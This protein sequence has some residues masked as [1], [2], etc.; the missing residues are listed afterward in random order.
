VT[1]RPYDSVAPPRRH[2]E[3]SRGAGD[4]APATTRHS[5]RVSE[6]TCDPPLASSSFDRE[7]GDFIRGKGLP[8][9]RAVMKTA[10]QLER[11]HNRTSLR[12]PRLLRRARLAHGH[13]D[14]CDAADHDRARPQCVQCD[15]G[16][17]SSR[18]LDYIFVSVDDSARMAHCAPSMC[19]HGT[20]LYEAPHHRRAVVHRATRTI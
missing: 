9:P 11:P 17:Y 4:G 12:G 2:R 10:N 16:G 14:N 1:S 15:V 19:R 3:W 20:I 18:R 7:T 5:L 13:F 8:S 6:C